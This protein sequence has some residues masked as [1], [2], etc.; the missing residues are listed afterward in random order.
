MIHLFVHKM[1][2]NH[3]TKIG[4][5]DLLKAQQ[6][7]VERDSNLIPPQY[8]MNALTTAPCSRTIR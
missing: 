4:M 8:R 2:Q 7:W 1:V 6:W 3:T 5:K